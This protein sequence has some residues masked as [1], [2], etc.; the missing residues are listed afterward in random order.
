[1]E[2][3]FKRLFV[4]GFSFLFWLLCLMAS[5]IGRETRWRRKGWAWTNRSILARFF[6]CLLKSHRKSSLSFFFSCTNENLFVQGNGS[7]NR[8]PVYTNSRRSET[9]PPLPPYRQQ[10]TWKRLYS[11]TRKG[12]WKKTNKKKTNMRYSFAVNSWLGKK[13]NHVN[14]TTKV[15]RRKDR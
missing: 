2:L 9:Q 15:L 4:M 5:W 8:N 11:T 6:F 10:I 3:F 7:R 13:G 12:S 14:C 1:M